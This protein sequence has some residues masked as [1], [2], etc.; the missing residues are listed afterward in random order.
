[1]PRMANWRKMWPRSGAMN[2]GM[3]ERKKRAVFGLRASV[4]TP[5]LKAAAAAGRKAADAAGWSGFV[6]TGGFALIE[7]AG[8][9]ARFDTEDRFA[10]EGTACRAPTGRTSSAFSGTLR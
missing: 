5:C 3:K 7:G 4:R 2:C 1:M 6:V 10:G 9:L 8:W